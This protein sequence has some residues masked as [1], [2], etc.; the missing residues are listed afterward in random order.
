[1]ALTERT[2]NQVNRRED[3]LRRIDVGAQRA[4]RVARTGRVKMRSCPG[5]CRGAVVGAVV[6]VVREGSHRRSGSGGAGH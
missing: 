1:M 4:M 6:G 2:S 3:P 5:E